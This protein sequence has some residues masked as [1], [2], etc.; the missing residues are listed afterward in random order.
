MTKAYVNIKNGVYRKTPV[1]NVILPL[2]HNLR[3]GAKGTPWITV[4]NSGLFPDKPEIIR[5]NVKGVTAFSFASEADFLA[6]DFASA[7]SAAP[8]AV[9][10]ETDD[11]VMARIADRFEILHDMARAA[12]EGTIRAQIVTGPPGIGKSF[13]VEAE[14]E[15]ASLFDRVSGKRIRSEV[16]KGAATPIGLYQILYKFAGKDDVIV[17]DDCD[18]LF[19]DDLSLNL[20]K[21]ALDTS[22]RRKIC[23]NSESNALRAAGIPDTFDFKG[24]IIFIT[25]LKFE[26]IKSKKLQDHLVALESRCHYLDLTLDTPREKLLRIKQ[27]A[28]TGELFSEYDFDKSQED[29]VIQFLFDNSARLREISLRTALKI[30]DLYKSFPL[31]WKKMATVTVMKGAQ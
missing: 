30:A 6:Q 22:K 28:A 2:V 4:E 29:E 3:T 16:I 27:I 18:M 10:K 5:I 8:A 15:R 13:G 21:S 19:Y 26:N 31:K 9:G 7:I 20:L 14:L 25:N 11:E 24:S 12:C 23:W 1:K 17:F